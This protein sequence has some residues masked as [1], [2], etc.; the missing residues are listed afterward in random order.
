MIVMLHRV[1]A[2]QT[3][4]ILNTFHQFSA[5]QVFKPTKAHAKR[6]SFYMVAINIQTQHPA[7]IK[8]LKYWKNTWSI[9]TFGSDEEYVAHIH[10]DGS[11]ADTTLEGF[12]PTLI[13]MG[14]EVWDTQARALERA[15][16]NAG[17]SGRSKFPRASFNVGASGQSRLARPWRRQ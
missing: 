17:A 4:G 8:A 16:F 9:A 11:W 2:A 12:G 5:V 3:G 1:E 6:S 10:R 15:P 13:S 14:K 7:A